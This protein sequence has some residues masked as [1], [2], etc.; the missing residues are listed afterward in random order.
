MAGFMCP[1]EV[2]RQK[3]WRRTV[4]G[5][6]GKTAK[7]ASFATS[8]KWY[9]P[10]TTAHPPPEEMRCT[11]SGTLF[12]GVRGARRANLPVCEGTDPRSRTML[13]VAWS[14]RERP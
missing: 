13:R 11:E 5:K 8:Q 4:R 3:T 10:T 1:N 2:R 7:T 12:D 9:Y 6:M 14:L